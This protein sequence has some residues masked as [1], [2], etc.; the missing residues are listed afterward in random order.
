VLVGRLVGCLF[1]R[2]YERAER[3]F[4]A[5]LLRGYTGRLPAAAPLRF[6]AADALMLAVFLPVLLAVRVLLR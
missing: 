2:S 1:V 5:M 6:G 3:T 4:G